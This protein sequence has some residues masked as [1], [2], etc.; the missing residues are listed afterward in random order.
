MIWYIESLSKGGMEVFSAML[1]NGLI[2]L[3]FLLIVLGALYKKIN[4]FDAFVEGAKG[5][6]KPRLRS[7]PIW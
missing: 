3:I 1:S 5:A 4:V 7:F 6:S 2:L